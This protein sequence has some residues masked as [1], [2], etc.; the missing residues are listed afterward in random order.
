MNHKRFINKARGFTLVELMVVIGIIAIAVAVTIGALTSA[1]QGSKVLSET[2]NLQ[3]IIAKSRSS[4]SS[5][6]NYTGISNGILLSQNGFPSS[7][8]DTAT[9]TVTNGWGG[10]VTV[11]AGTPATTANI[12]YSDVP[13]GACNELVGRVARNFNTITVGSTVV[14][15][16]TV[17]TNDLT[18]TQTACDASNTASVTFNFQ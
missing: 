17:S 6:Q 10:T 18:A 1:S 4:F 2:S 16:A 13:S 7:M 12:V 5:R 8:V 9:S 15:T 11:A 3:T 14:K